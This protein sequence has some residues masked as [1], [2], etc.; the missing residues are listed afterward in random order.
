VTRLLSLAHGGCAKPVFR[1]RFMSEGKL[2]A[3][4]GRQT[5]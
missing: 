2:V 4:H 3:G 5:G 1:P